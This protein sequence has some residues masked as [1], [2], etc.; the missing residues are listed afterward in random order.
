MYGE[1][2]SKLNFSKNS[3]DKWIQE[4]EAKNLKEQ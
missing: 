2:G 4:Q 1:Y 3:I